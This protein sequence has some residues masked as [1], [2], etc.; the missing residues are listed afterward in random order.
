MMLPEAVQESVAVA[1]DQGHF[2]GPHGHDRQSGHEFVE[3]EIPAEL[4]D[5]GV[6]Q[7]LVPRD[8]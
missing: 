7:V 8:G 2:D 1:G 5:E 4:V 3:V 6:G